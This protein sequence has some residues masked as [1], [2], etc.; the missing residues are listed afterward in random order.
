MT[1]TSPYVSI[2]HGNNSVNI[3]NKPPKSRVIQRVFKKE[4]SV[5]KDWKEDTPQILSKAMEH[6]EKEWKAMRFIKDPVEVEACKRVIQQNFQKLKDVFITL[7]SRS[8][9]PTVSLLDFT[10]F[11]N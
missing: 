10:I 6:D 8:N 9:F 5:F 3:E 2:A 7:A 1:R 11:A 4:T